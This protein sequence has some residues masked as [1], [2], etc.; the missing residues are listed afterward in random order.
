M[1]LI[2]LIRVIAPTVS[3][4]RSKISLVVIIVL[5]AKALFTNDFIDSALSAGI[6]LSILC[7]GLKMLLT[8]DA[9]IVL[10]ELGLV[11]SYVNRT[12]KFKGVT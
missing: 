1:T 12:F 3:S 7:L 10:G 2:S 11:F 8:L 9:A 6:E 5:A 4:L